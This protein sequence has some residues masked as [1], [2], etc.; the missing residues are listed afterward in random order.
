[1]SI[2]VSSSQYHLDSLRHIQENAG[3][4]NALS[5]QLATNQRIQAPSD[6]PIGSV[7]LLTLNA[8][9]ETLDQ[10]QTN[11]DSVNYNLG[12][13]ET[14]LS[15]LVE[16]LY[17]IQ[18]LTTRAASDDNSEAELKAYGQE[19]SELADTVVDLLNA[20][21]GNGRYHFSGSEIDT[22][23]FQQD[24]VTGD[25]SYMGDN[26]VRQVAVSANSE[27][28][29]NIT[30]AA[31][32]GND[33]FLNAM[34]EYVELLNAPP[35]GGVG[36]ESRDFLE[37]IGDFQGRVSGEITRIGATLASTDELK[38][39]NMDISEFVL[40]LQTEI[41]TVDAAESRIKINETLNAYESSLQ[42]YSS[43]S[44]LSL[45]SFLR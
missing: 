34:Q 21:D 9:L 28:P 35:A 12:Q 8:Q 40:E 11:M 13:Q 41:Q 19:L 5:V 38:N 16:V 20:E 33:D 14:Q 25:Y 31:L 22:Q 10:Y 3:R 45:F 1:M 23:P 37:Q 27:V 29:T 26:N 6:D 39:I 4:Y 24:P 32:D 15:G 36:D 30:G 43:V 44:E 17:S 7:S 42:V 2:R 18:S